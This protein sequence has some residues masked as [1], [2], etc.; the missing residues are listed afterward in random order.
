MT[1]IAAAIRDR[2]L[3]DIDRNDQHKPDDEVRD[4]RKLVS[5]AADLLEKTI[6]N[7]HCD[8]G[9]A[10]SAEPNSLTAVA[11]AYVAD[12]RSWTRR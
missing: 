8:G 5:D 4:V 10:V 9:L 12:G 2:A 6:R 11:G 7:G 1:G 3:A